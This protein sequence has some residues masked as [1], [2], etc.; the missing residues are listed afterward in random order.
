MRRGLLAL[1]EHLVF[2]SLNLVPQLVFGNYALTCAV[3][4][5]NRGMVL[6][7]SVTIIFSEN[8]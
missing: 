4:V 5:P 7:C 3:L 6:N 1:G 8:W 2:V